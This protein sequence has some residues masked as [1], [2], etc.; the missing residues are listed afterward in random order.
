MSE[1]FAPCT[2]LRNV[3]VPMRDGVKLATTVFIPNGEGP[4]PVALVRTAYN[5]VGFNGVD[6]TNRGIAF[7]VQDCRGRY[8][9]EGDWYPFTAEERD[10]EDTLEWLGAQPWCNGRVA[11][12]GD[13]YLAATSFYAAL[14]GSKWLCAVNPRF[15]AGDCWKRAYYC[16]GAFS[17][18]LTWSWLCFECSARTSEAALM[19]LFDVRG[20]L[21]SLPILSM[22]ERSGAGAAPWYR[23]YVSHNRYDD[24]WAQMNVRDSFSRVRVPMFL[25]GGWYDYYAG[26]T[27]A[28]Y[29]SLLRH[30]DPGVRDGHRVLVGPWTHGIGGSSTL[31]EIDFGAAAL[32]ENDATM[33]WLECVLEGR[34]P[35]EYQA[36]PIRL[37][38]MGINEWRD[39]YEWPL[40]RTCFVNYYLRA[41]G[42]LSAAPP[43][44]EPPDSFDYDPANPVWT[45]GGNHSVGPYNPG[46]YEFVKP[47]PYDQRPVESRDDVLVYTSEVL[48]QDTEVTGPVVVQ[49]YAAS[50]A[51]D[52]DFV[53]KLTDVYP[54]GRSM[55]IT[56][57]VIRARFRESI[58]GEPKLLEPGQC[59]EFAIDL[60]ATSNVFLAG[61][62]I[63]LDITSS[64]FP[65]LDRNLNTGN[66]PATDV[67]RVI[68][69]QTIFHDAEHPSRIILPVIPAS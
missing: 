18:A 32:A 51:R 1:A 25:I 42:G 14:S 8:D 56:E 21:N 37:F 34:S 55:N 45:L 20:I 58:W 12:F 63:R 67:D 26:E 41:D 49:L 2:I 22:D 39:E 15:M 29:Q 3:K 38:V 13:S 43:A 46:L 62:R 44:N 19:P 7:V 57:G 31:G 69:H 60:Q 9:S 54:D 65:L 27:F 17:L 47:G 30:A 28:N 4:F 35:A 23:D 24:L 33:R 6:F 5:R 10:G 68:A 52:T 48:E 53:V 66:D 11:M 40:A 59:Y 16:D 61:H 50:S 64:N 36:A